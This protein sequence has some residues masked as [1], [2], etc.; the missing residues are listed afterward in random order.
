MRFHLCR[1]FR[2]KYKQI[3]M[4]V[5]VSRK[6]RLE[7]MA[8]KKAKIDTDKFIDPWEKEENLWN[9]ILNE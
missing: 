8:G 1:S 9:V 4:C 5:F 6:N 3:F 7:V 2:E